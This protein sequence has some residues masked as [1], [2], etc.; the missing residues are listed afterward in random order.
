MT[1]YKMSDLF[2]GGDNMFHVIP[3]LGCGKNPGKQYYMRILI[4]SWIGCVAEATAAAATWICLSVIK[5]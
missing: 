1:I 5:I 2:G 4:D 3:N